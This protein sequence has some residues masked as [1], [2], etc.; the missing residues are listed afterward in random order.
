MLVV[1]IC[2]KRALRLTRLCVFHTGQVRSCFDAVWSTFV[3]SVIR[4]ESR[5]VCLTS[6][7]VKLK[8]QNESTQMFSYS[9][10]LITL[11]ILTQLTPWNEASLGSKGIP[12]FY[13]SRRLIVVLKEAYH[14][15]ICRT[16]SDHALSQSHRIS[17]FLHTGLYLPIDFF[18][19]CFP[20]M[21]IYIYFHRASPTSQLTPY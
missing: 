2:A 19:Q 7:S 16:T 12:S 20:I 4:S 10:L 17:R 1:C 3:F 5:P 8:L 15:I 6:S 21:Y 18:L 11:K 9:A 14:W 13:G